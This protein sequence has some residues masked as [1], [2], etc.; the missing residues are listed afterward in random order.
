M[1]K[2]LIILFIMSIALC[3]AIPQVNAQNESSDDSL[4]PYEEVLSFYQ[5]QQFIVGLIL[6]L[7]S[8]IKQD[9]IFRKNFPDETQKIQKSIEESTLLVYEAG[10][11][12]KSWEKERERIVLSSIK[13]LENYSVYI[14]SR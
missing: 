12:I 8:L 10:Q 11:N 6:D 1:K 9:Y 14:K 3:F 5:S 7:D 13:L 4:P 2:V